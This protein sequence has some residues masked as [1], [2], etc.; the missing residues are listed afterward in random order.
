MHA[1][2]SAHTLDHT[3][4]V[5]DWGTYDWFQDKCEEVDPDSDLDEVDEH[6][7]PIARE[8]PIKGQGSELLHKLMRALHLPGARKRSGR[9]GKSGK[10]PI[11]R[12]ETPLSRMA[13][14]RNNYNR[15]KMIVARQIEKGLEPRLNRFVSTEPNDDVFN[16]DDKYKLI[17]PRGDH[18]LNSYWAAPP[19]AKRSF[20]SY[21]DDMFSYYDAKKAFEQAHPNA[22]APLTGL[23]S[24]DFRLNGQRRGEV[25][26]DDEDYEESLQAALAHQRAQEAGEAD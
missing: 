13:R 22:F 19:P 9:K 10:T 6:G 26:S 12:E 5:E 3:D 15:R 8:E 4:G 21:I 2:V 17:H 1:H 20:T 7:R 16:L 23:D 14:R 25:F 18:L 11:V 24:Y